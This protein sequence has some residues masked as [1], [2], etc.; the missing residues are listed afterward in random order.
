[1]EL[2]IGGWATVQKR[3]EDSLDDYPAL[4]GRERSQGTYL[5]FKAV[6][7]V[8]EEEAMQGVAGLPFHQDRGV[9]AGVMPSESNIRGMKVKED[10]HSKVEK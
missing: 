2:R 1:M 3:W 5:Q 4:S 10:L 7:E 9:G 6:C 8:S